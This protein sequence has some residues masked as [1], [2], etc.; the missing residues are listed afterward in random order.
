MV[1]DGRVPPGMVITSD[2]GGDFGINWSNGRGITRMTGCPDPKGQVKRG[3]KLVKYYSIEELADFL[4][5]KG[6]SY[7]KN[8]KARIPAKFNVM[9]M[10][11]ATGRARKSAAT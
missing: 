2:I 6:I 3:G 4:D 10:F 1:S 5:G 7:S 8:V 9:A 11:A